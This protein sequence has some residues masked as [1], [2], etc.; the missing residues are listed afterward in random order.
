[1]SILSVTLVDGLSG[2][3]PRARLRSFVTEVYPDLP[4]IRAMHAEAREA[5]VARPCNSAIIPFS[6]LR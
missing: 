5:S 1:M 6:T 2:A 4:I 3:E